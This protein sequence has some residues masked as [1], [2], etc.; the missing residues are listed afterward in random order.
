MT[1]IANVLATILGWFTSK[2]GRVATIVTIVVA[3]LGTLW[4]SINVS[5]NALI[6][7][8]SSGGLWFNFWMGVSFFIPEN[9]S[10]CIALMFGADV[11]VF[12][13]RIYNRITFAG[14]G[15]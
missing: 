3:L 7:T 2:I 4:A 10:N 9:F 13:Y 8:T 14:V 15:A 1:F 5:L 6:Y 11:S 12:M